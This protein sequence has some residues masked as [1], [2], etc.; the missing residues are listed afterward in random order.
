MNV[1][2]NLQAFTLAGGLLYALLAFATWTLL[3]AQRHRLPIAMW[4]LGSFIMGVGL[5]LLAAREA[6]PPWATYTLSNGLGFT[7]FVLRVMALRLDLQ[8]PVRWRVGVLAVLVWVAGY[9]VC[10]DSAYPMA[11]V[12]YAYVGYL[13]GTAALA[14]NAWRLGLAAQSRSGLVLARVE[15]V[16]AVALALRV[17]AIMAGWVA[18]QPIGQG[19]DFAALA[20]I[21]FVAGLY[22]NLGYM[23]L[24][25]DRA[26]NAEEHARAERLGERFKR[27]LAE[28]QSEELRTMLDQRNRLAT[29]RDRLLRVLAHEIRQPLHNASGALQSATEVLRMPG[30]SRE[31]GASD[32]LLRAQDVLGDVRSVLDNTLIASDMLA[33]MAPLSKDDVDLIVLIELTI[34][35]LS[36]SQR[37]RVSVQRLTMVRT[38]ALDPGLT[39]VA[40]R[41]LLRNAFKHGGDGVRV[42]I[43]V[44]EQAEPPATVLV[45]EDDGVGMAHPQAFGPSDPPK[46]LDWPADHEGLG[47]FIVFRVMAL[48]GGHMKVMP[49]KPHG[50][51]VRLT[52]PEPDDGDDA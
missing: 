11:K 18:P 28:R 12:L 30:G 17:A 21:G 45:V 47:L 39:R 29:E 52:F 22:G 3:D 20:V 33:R 23:G 8:R 44:E 16:Y 34:G 9:Q 19:W 10:L 6:V 2:L 25:L 7:S 41:N 48:H 1:P 24:A 42:R 26:R 15:G 35:D 46:V 5:M 51:T 38:V 13:A 14:W 37:A 36:T 49:T 50:M 31:G 4:S 43:R 27:E 40:L 32:R